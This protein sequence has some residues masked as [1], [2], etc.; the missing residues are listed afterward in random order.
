MNYNVQHFLEQCLLSVQKAIKG[1]AAEV[2]IVDNN[3][4][5]NSVV[6]LE[7]EFPDSFLLKNKEN[8]GFGKAC[9]QGAA[10]AKGEYILFLNP[11]TIV[12]EDCFTKCISFFEQQA[13]AG[14]LGIKMLDGKG[15]F[16]RESKRS[17]PSPLTSLYKLFGLSALFPHSKTFSRYHLGHLSENENHEVDVLAGAFMM[18]KKEA[19]DK[20]GLFDETFFMY[21]EDVDLSFRIQELGYK[22]YYFAGSQVIHFKG[23]STKKG[24]MNYVK[25]FYNAMSIFVQKHYGTGKARFF[26]FLI[27]A[28]IIF[29]GALS[30]IAGFIRRNGLPLLDA[31]LILFSFLLIKKIWTGYIKT[32][33]EYKTGLLIIALPAFTALYLL[34]AY[35]AGLYDR[36][37]KRLE[38]IQ[39]TSIAT[40][41]LLAAYSLLPEDYRFSRGIIVFGAILAF[42]LISLLRWV[43]IKTNVIVKAD[44]KN[45]H[46]NTMIVGTP[47]EYDEV[48]QLLQSAGLKEKVLGRIAVDENDTTG[49][50]YWSR[51]PLLLEAVPFREIIYCQ[52][53][54][55][56]ADI[57]NTIG[58]LPSQ[59][60]IKIHSSGSHSIVGSDSKNS[61]GE[62][63]SKEN[64]YRLADPYNRRLKR[65][66]DVLIA[67]GGLIT[68][69]IHLLLMKKGVSFLK[70]CV[71]ILAA[72]KTWVG[73]AISESRLPALRKAILAPNGIPIRSVQQLP[74]ESLQMVDYWYARDYRP[75]SDLKLAWKMYRKL[76][77]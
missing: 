66:L 73:Y 40:L 75:I 3:S 53:K 49:I 71:D 65:L 14:A 45:E 23:E 68:F 28:A 9:N 24:S 64:G 74:S 44:D 6:F 4:S 72:K 38:L 5:D 15:N 31:L 52:G 62:A 69:P 17:F 46:G 21:G 60:S 29:R 30:A 10:I 77:S 22:N 63:L 19:L 57:I 43:L 42:L 33:T 34:S 67:I 39:T 27:Q 56:Y 36:Y 58:E 26:N 37:Y 25:M 35:Y 13:D 16:L 18:I 47:H 32:D 70:N 48:K 1:I 54:L 51:V 76:G 2:I 20:T 59:L 11:D 8:I 7:T 12:P 50:G 61:V 55:S 41:I